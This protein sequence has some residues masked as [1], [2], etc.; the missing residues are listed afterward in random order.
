MLT[1]LIVEDNARLAAALQ[2]GFAATGL[3]N[4]LHTCA[5]GED[6]LAWCLAQSAAG[7]PTPQAVLMDVQLAGAHERDPG[8]RRPAP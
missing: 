1:L 8:G 5:A 7:E 4:V 6:A 2:A 3:V